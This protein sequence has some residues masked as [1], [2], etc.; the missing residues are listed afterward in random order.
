[1]RF[2]YGLIFCLCVVQIAGAD[3]QTPVQAVDISHWSGTI[4]P[5][6]VACWKTNGI[7][8]VIPGT[9]NPGITRQQLQTA[10]AGGLSADAYVVLYW[11]QNMAAQVQAALNTIAGFPIGRL[12]LDVEVYPGSRTPAQ[13]EGLIGDAL[14]ACGSTPCG[15]YTAKWWWDAYM[16]GSTAFASVPLWYANY[17]G[18][19][20]LGSWAWQQFGGWVEPTGKQ[21]QVGYLCGVNV[22][23]NIIH[24]DAPSGGNP[25]PVPT[26]LWPDRGTVIRTASV[27]LSADPVSGATSYAFEIVYFDGATWHDYYTYR[28]GSATQTFWPAFSSTAY[29]WRIRAEN[30]AGASDWPAWAGFNFGDVGT[31][32]PAP[33]NP[34]PPD[35]AH[36]TTSSVTLSV[37]PID[38]ASGYAFE[39]EYWDGLSW[40]TYYT[41]FPTAS[42]QTF[43]PAFADT[44]YRWR[45][46]AENTFGWG[47][48]SDWTGFDFGNVA[49]VPPAP[50]G[51]TPDA[52]VQITTSSVTLQVDLVSGGTGYEFEIN[53][54]DGANWQYYYTYFS[55]TNSQRFWP[56]FANLAYRW[57][58]RAEN[59]YGWGDWSGWSTFILSL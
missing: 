22:D 13:L 40:Q 42:H 54:W 48:S 41:Y 55:S 10:L 50:T 15:I 56:Q 34:S 12:W 29:R 38:G 25:P 35:G 24:T 1:M 36:V 28:S 53:Y 58:V 59:S 14:D 47:E 19:P 23:F 39:I 49:R 30:A 11:D 20:S 21:Y 37:E 17:D 4:S 44:T 2:L 26:N 46:R 57:R 33:V 9:Q 51:L 7:E 8:H 52:G 45:A 18:N 16:R 31:T 32:P 27:T 43:W 5:D 6:D 3:P